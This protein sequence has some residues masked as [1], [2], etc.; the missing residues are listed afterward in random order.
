M[1]YIVVRHFTDLQD[2]NH[3]YTEGDTYPREGY[4]PSVERIQEL[5]GDSNKQGV[6]LIELIPEA[7][8]EA[9]A[10]AEVAEAE[11]KPKK[12]SRKKTDDN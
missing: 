7:V 4:A 5:A 8:A 12:R 2:S 6:P 11:E 10:P 3:K 1:S 9:E